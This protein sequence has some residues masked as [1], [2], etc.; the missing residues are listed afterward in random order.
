MSIFFEK[1]NK[2]KSTKPFTILKLLLTCLMIAMLIMSIWND[3]DIFYVRLVFVFVGINSFAEAIESYIQR[4]SKKTIKRE[5]ILGVLFILL[6][7]L[8]Q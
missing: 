4:E 6:A 5:I 8:L 7:I 2:K 3:N 1:T